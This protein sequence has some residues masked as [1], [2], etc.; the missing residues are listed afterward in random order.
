MQH[1]FERVVKD[2]GE[3]HYIS[4]VENSNKK[5]YCGATNGAYVINGFTSTDIDKQDN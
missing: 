2:K 4:L 5:H 3:G 1:K